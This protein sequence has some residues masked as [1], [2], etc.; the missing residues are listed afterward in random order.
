MSNQ[1]SGASQ[2]FDEL[3]AKI[4]DTQQRLQDAFS[5]IGGTCDR[6]LSNY[7]TSLPRRNHRSVHSVKVPSRV[8]IDVDCEGSITISIDAI[9]DAR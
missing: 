4:K 8:T 2:L 5:S 9:D 6:I 1:P 3:E 7:Q